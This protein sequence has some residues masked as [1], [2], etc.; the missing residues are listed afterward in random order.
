MQAVGHE[1]TLLAP[2]AGEILPK[3]A[4]G[5]L[6]LASEPLGP[7]APAVNPVSGREAPSKGQKSRKS[8]YSQAY[9]GEAAPH[10]GT[11]VKKGRKF[12]GSWESYLVEGHSGPASSKSRSRAAS[13]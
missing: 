3:T 5:L 8:G 10:L 7:F 2:R 1:G 9:G 11:I 6:D 4:A 13:F 12:F